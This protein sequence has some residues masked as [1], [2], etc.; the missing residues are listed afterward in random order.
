MPKSYYHYIGGLLQGVILQGIP[1]GSLY[2]I[3]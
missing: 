1:D 2:G 3:L